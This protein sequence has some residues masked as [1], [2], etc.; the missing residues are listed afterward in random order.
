MLIEESPTQEAPRLSRLVY[1]IELLTFLLL[2]V[3]AM[4]LSYFDGHQA[5]AGFSLTAFATVF[6]DLGLVALV[7]FFT[8]RNRESLREIGLRMDRSALRE[9]GL[10]AALFIPFYFG[11]TWLEQF[12]VHIGLS[13][14]KD[15]SPIA[16]PS[17]TV[18]QIILGTVLV[19]VVGF[20]EELI[21]R[22]YLI[23]RFRHAGTGTA[24]AVILSTAIFA[25]GHG[26]EGTAGVATVSVMGLVF[27][28]VYLWR[29][30]LTASMT[31]HFLQDFVIVVALPVLFQR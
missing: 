4:I 22:G 7:V 21:F 10:G 18:S 3:P 13:V 23:D 15:F 28:I 26:Y 1:R 14:P 27:A 19:A 17:P 30:S 11:A 25:L 29:K 5:T 24:M 31:L 2:I 8:W 12:F 16:I 9:I 6:R 20:S